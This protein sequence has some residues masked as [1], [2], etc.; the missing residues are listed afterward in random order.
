MSVGGYFK[1]KAVLFLRCSQF[2][3]HAGFILTGSASQEHFGTRRTNKALPVSV[4]DGKPVKQ[5]HFSH[6]SSF[7]NFS[8]NQK[9]NFLCLKF[10]P[11]SYFLFAYTAFNR[12][13]T[14]KQAVEKSPILYM[15]LKTAGHSGNHKTLK[16]S[17]TQEL[18]NFPR[19]LQI[20]FAP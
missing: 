14:S 6:P 8:E 3:F 20:I 9:S 1:G 18:N 11:L 13:F 4:V 7:P 5:K 10:S 19:R 16:S 15:S 17:P 12:N 2:Y